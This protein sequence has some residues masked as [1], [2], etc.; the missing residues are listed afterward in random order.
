MEA[1]WLVGKPKTPPLESTTL[2]WSSF[3]TISLTA[4]TWLKWHYLKLCSLRDKWFKLRLLSHMK[5]CPSHWMPTM[6]RSLRSHSL[7]PRLDRTKLSVASMICLTP[8]VRIFPPMCA[9]APRMGLAIPIVLLAPVTGATQGRSA[10]TLI[11][12]SVVLLP[13]PLLLFQVSLATTSR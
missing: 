2:S 7:S 11:H 9:T 4:E 10:S 1:I 13:R 8:L 12:R 5:C 6:S 3:K